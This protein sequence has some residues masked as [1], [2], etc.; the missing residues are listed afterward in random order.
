ML[1][2]WL[3]PHKLLTQTSQSKPFKKLWSDV[4]V[5]LFCLL[6]HAHNLFLA[7]R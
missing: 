4:F 5:F 2:F 6:Q 3:H 7:L 1:S